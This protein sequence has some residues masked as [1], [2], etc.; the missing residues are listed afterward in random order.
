MQGVVAHTCNSSTGEAEQ[1]DQEFK[2]S[3]V[4][5]ARPCLKFLKNFQNILLGSFIQVNIF[6]KT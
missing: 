6:P 2:S 5:I 3:L 1:E 4:Y